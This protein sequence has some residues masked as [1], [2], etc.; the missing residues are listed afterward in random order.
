VIAIISTV[1]L[2]GVD[3]ATR[4]ALPLAVLLD[5][6]LVFPDEAPSRFRVA[7]RSGGT[8]TLQQRIEDYRAIGDDHP[9]EA[10][11]HVLELVA[12]LSQHDR[13]TRGH[14]ERVR[15]Y[16]NMIGNELG[17]DDEQV[18][19][20]QWAA[21]LHD[22]GKL[23]VPFEILNKPGKLDADE[24]DVIKTHPEIGAQFAA[25]L[26]GWLGEWV[27][28]VGQHHERWDGGGY[29]TGL[30]QTEICLAARIVSVADT[31]DVM[32]SIRSYQEASSSAT[33]RQELADC[34]GSQFDPAIVRA[35]LS[36]SLGKLR[37][38]MGPLS[39]LTQL[40]LFPPGIVSAGAAPAMTA[41]AGLTAATIGVAT[42]PAEFVRAEP[43]GYVMDAG[44]IDPPSPIVVVVPTTSSTSTTSTTSIPAAPRIGPTTT[45]SSPTTVARRSNPPPTPSNDT[46]T[47]TT[48]DKKKPATT[49]AT[50]TTI[51]E[52]AGTV[53]PRTTLPVTTT[54]PT[55][56]TT[57]PVIL[58][59]ATTTPPPTTS[60]PTTTTIPPTTTTTTTTIPPTTTTTT[61]TTI[62][63]TTT[64]TTTTT[65]PPNKAYL[66]GSP[67]IGDLVS[68]PILPLVVRAALNP[69]VPNF[70]TD[71]DD[72][73]GL[74][75][76][77]DGEFD[78]EQPD[79]LQRFRLDPSSALE[80]EGG[81]SAK[82]WIAAKDFKQDDVQAA[83]A[84]MECPDVPDDCTTLASATVDFVGVLGQFSLHHFEFGSLTRTIPANRNLQL[85]IIATEDSRHD[86]WVAYD[87]VGFESALTLNQ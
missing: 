10:A 66:L 26:A 59:P 44:P 36:I 32:T 83:V 63:P 53:P 54:A 31:F 34:A 15:A 21:L 37:M 65:V 50:T 61:T 18:D 69:A 68:Q 35:F 81:A 78:P 71:R 46:P 22:I 20:L 24:Y 73:P 57:P 67:R 5:L 1:V 12:A 60:P 39:W 6:T 17:L 77:N 52:R 25:P 7:L 27:H 70:D 56:A 72:E 49:T 29:P 2:F 8:R 41:V 43:P 79:H 51:P 3:R 13:R 9:A 30:R 82:I 42:G 23:E 84:L 87:T 28:A 74:K 47:A 76:K 80:L 40:S 85:W 62:P 14:S 55:T 38:A 48:P 16:A 58:A 4:K 75:I 33:A 64:T 11:E 19:K 45:T 86:M